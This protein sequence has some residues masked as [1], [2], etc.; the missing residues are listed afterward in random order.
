MQEVWWHRLDLDSLDELTWKDLSSLR[1]HSPTTG[2]LMPLIDRQVRG[3]LVGLGLY[4]SGTGEDFLNCSGAP[5]VLPASAK[6]GRLASSDAIFGNGNNV[7]TGVDMMGSSDGETMM[8]LEDWNMAESFRS[9]GPISPAVPF[10]EHARKLIDDDNCRTRSI[11]SR[12]VCQ[13]WMMDNG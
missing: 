1:L 3:A 8:V 13:A 6:Q 2:E 12:L 10:P 5:R 4:G 11:H 9:A 7:L